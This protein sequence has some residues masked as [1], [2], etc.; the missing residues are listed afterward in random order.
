MIADARAVS[1]S[2]RTSA[3]FTAS[4]ASR[5]SAPLNAAFSHR[6]V[7][8]SSSTAAM[9]VAGLR[10]SSRRGSRRG[11][12]WISAMAGTVGAPR[13]RLCRVGCTAQQLNRLGRS[14]CQR[15]NQKGP[16]LDRSDFL[17]AGIK[18]NFA[19]FQDGL[20]A[21]QFLALCER[22]TLF[23]D[24]RERLR[25]GCFEC[26]H[27]MIFRADGGV[28]HGHRMPDPWRLD[29]LSPRSPERHRGR[30]FGTA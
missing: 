21:G 10:P 6:L 22:S 7:A 2:T 14:D 11:M 15:S 23:P 12:S 1:N 8:G 17:R 9:H 16:Q 25:S 30:V 29:K 19:Q 26:R 13:C 18:N 5:S 3:S 20:I 28:D 4:T 27:G 24:P